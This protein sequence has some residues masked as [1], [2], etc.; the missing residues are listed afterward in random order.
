MSYRA[1]PMPMPMLALAFMSIS[2]M[3]VSAMAQTLNFLMTLPRE[4]RPKVG[5]LQ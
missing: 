5:S 3:G 1:K 2:L 4:R